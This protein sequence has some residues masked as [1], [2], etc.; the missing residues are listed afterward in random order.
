MGPRYKKI[1]AVILSILS[2]L[3]LFSVVLLLYDPSMH[4]LVFMLLSVFEM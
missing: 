3:L 2:I 1:D 4:S